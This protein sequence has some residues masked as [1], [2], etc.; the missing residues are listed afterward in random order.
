VGNASFPNSTAA[1]AIPGTFDIL[2]VVAV[3]A[4]GAPTS[5]GL[6]LYGA[7]RISYFWGLGSLPL[8]FLLHWYNTLLRS[9]AALVRFDRG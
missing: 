8:V 9:V 1:G 7:S 6:S 4:A 2:F 3:R 5:C